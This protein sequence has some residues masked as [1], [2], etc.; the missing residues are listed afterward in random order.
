MSSS[1]FH[2]LGGSGRLRQRKPHGTGVIQCQTDVLAVQL[3]TNSGGELAVDH[4]L[5]VQFQ[6]STSLSSV[7]PDVRPSAA[8]GLGSF[9]IP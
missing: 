5:A 7:I 2:Q 9:V 8:Q 3:D 6:R 4:P 1:N